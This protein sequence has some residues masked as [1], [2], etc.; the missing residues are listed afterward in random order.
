MIGNQVVHSAAVLMGLRQAATQL[1][2]GETQLLESLAAE[3]RTIAEIGVFEGVT[4]RRMVE[5]MPSGGIMVC[6]DPFFAGRLG[7]AYGYLITRAQLRRARR[8]D[9]VIRIVRKLS[10][11][12][13]PEH[14][15]EFDLIFI[16]ADHRYEAVKRD[17]GDWSAKVKLGGRIALHDSRPMAGRCPEP[18]GPVRLVRELGEA[19]RGFKIR[20]TRDTITVFQRVS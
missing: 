1:S 6:I 19:P 20:E 18:S 15:G 2:P 3:A 5:R 14:Q 12:Y 11:E 4:S 7:I 9:V 8:H 16:D 17:W 13:A 10:H